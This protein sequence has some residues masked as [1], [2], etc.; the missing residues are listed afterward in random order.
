MY[1]ILRV[2]CTEFH[3]FFIG[4]RG[5]F[6]TPLHKNGHLIPAT[7]RKVLPIGLKPAV[8]VR[9]ATHEEH[10][11]EVYLNLLGAVART[12]DHGH[13]ENDESDAGSIC[14]QD[15]RKGISAEALSDGVPLNL[16]HVP[17]WLLA[18]G[19]PSTQ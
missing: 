15:W 17:H 11:V 7:D 3:S 8:N 4:S 2:N 16:L 6:T 9:G 1:P 12:R 19:L 13:I 10:L 14:E 18:L 5:R